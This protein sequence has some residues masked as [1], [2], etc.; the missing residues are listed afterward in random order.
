MTTASRW[1]EAIVSRSS[2]SPPPPPLPAVRGVSA[3][4]V[5]NLSWIRV[6]PH[7]LVDSANRDCCICLQPH[8]LHPDDDDSS[9]AAPLSVIRLPCAHIFHAECILPWLQTASNT[10]PVCRYEL[11][12][13]DPHVEAQRIHRMRHRR[14]RYTYGEL[15]QMSL[16]DLI[17]MKRENERDDES[18]T[19]MFLFDHQDWIQHLV[20]RRDIELIPDPPPVMRSMGQLQS[21]TVTELVSCMQD[22]GV[23]FHPEHVSERSALMEL[24]VTSGL[25]HITPDRDPNMEATTGERIAA[26]QGEQA[27]VTTDRESITADETTS[28]YVLSPHTH[29]DD[30][31]ELER[32]ANNAET[33]E[34]SL[35]EAFNQQNETAVVVSPSERQS[36]PGPERSHAVGPGSRGRRSHGSS[37][38]PTV[39]P[40]SHRP[41]HTQSNRMTSSRHSQARNNHRPPAMVSSMVVYEMGNEPGHQR[42]RNLPHADSRPFPVV[43]WHSPP[44]IQRTEE[45]S[46]SVE[47]TGGVH[48]G[49]RGTFVKRTEKRIGVQL[50]ECPDQCKYLMPANVRFLQN[51]NNND[52]GAH[53]SPVQNA[54]ERPRVVARQNSSLRR[55]FRVNVYRSQSQVPAS[56][57]SRLAMRVEVIGGTHKGR[58]GTFVKRTEQRIGVQLENSDGSCRYFKPDNVRFLGQDDDASYSFSSRRFV[59]TFVRE[60]HA[61]YPVA[62]RRQQP[63][64]GMSIRLVSSRT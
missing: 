34:S 24:F 31:P 61:G 14:P 32:F 49:K 27:E 4:A 16:T 10:C 35:G 22:A 17:M 1:H 50:D 8:C 36:N 57:A 53:H 47:I 39:T 62:P 33:L 37:Q 28:N 7:H 43:S 38:V 51:N 19:E 54:V 6:A 9:A 25:L 26:E 63:T 52:D 64:S 21:M 20:E 59:S 23:W 29:Q 3:Q 45:T 42:A 12:S 46:M 30:E 56:S 48:K 40:S 13:E 41:A 58:L 15:H 44:P 18:D 55:E 2:H 60:G 11:Q 5:T